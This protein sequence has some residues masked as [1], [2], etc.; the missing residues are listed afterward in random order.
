MKNLM[1][2]PPY[3]PGT[4]IE[5]R[6]V[7]YLFT[8]GGIGDYI[9]WTPALLWLAKNHPFLK[10]RI[11]VSPYALDLLN[12]IFRETSWRAYN[13]SFYN[14]M[15]EEGSHLYAPMQAELGRQ[16]LNA[17]GAH[18]T[19]CGFAYFCNLAPPPVGADILPHLSFPKDSLPDQLKGKRYVVLTPGATTPV[20][21]LPGWAWNAIASSCVEQDLTPVWLGKG[22]LAKG[23]EARFDE[24]LDL[25]VGINLIERTS[26]TTAASIMQY[27]VAVV[28]LDNGLLHLASCTDAKMIFG[29]NIAGPGQRRPRRKWGRLIEIYL[30]SDDLSCANCQ[31]GGDNAGMKQNHLHD[32]SRCYYGDLKCINLLCANGAKRWIEAIE[33]ADILA[34]ME[35][36]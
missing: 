6:K 15:V 32:F 19:D 9:C 5:D 35:G 8:G 2:S 1:P 11:W 17:T 12:L 31:G 10:G 14:Q 13:I 22:K 21:A 36:R 34:Q 33:T 7:E 23:H 26:L 24:E 29:Y 27:S 28:G 30:T 25:S 18:L 4:Y 16:L 3:R 20:R